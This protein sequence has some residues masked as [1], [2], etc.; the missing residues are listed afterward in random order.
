MLTKECGLETRWTLRVFACR[1]KE[2]G[3]NKSSFLKILTILT[4]DFIKSV[5]EDFC[6]RAAFSVLG[7]NLD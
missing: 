7:M 4:K 5:F 2:S 1:A 3:G 6:V